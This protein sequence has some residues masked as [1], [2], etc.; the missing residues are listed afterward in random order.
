MRRSV[1]VQG[2]RS[3]FALGREVERRRALGAWLMTAAG[4]SA[5]APRLLGSCPPYK[6]KW[7][8]TEIR[9]LPG[10]QFQ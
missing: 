10:G 5:A 2:G 3:H 8:E 9:R 1:I 7:S 4:F 6:V